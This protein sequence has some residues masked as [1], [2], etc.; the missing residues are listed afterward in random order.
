MP[1]KTKAKGA[2]RPKARISV[3]PSSRRGLIAIPSEE[4]VVEPFRPVKDANA[5]PAPEKCR[6]TLP[7]CQKH[8]KVCKH[9][10][11]FICL[12]H[13]TDPA[14]PVCIPCKNPDTRIFSHN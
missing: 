8:G 14:N 10:K 9:C 11:D 1:V 13:L 12:N 4:Q 3:S 2:A 5:S 6:G 7:G